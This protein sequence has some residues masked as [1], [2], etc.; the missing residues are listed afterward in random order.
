MVANPMVRRVA[1]VEAT[2]AQFNGKPLAYGKSDC[3]RMIAFALKKQ[4]HRVSLLKGGRYSSA[5]GACRALKTLGFETVLD[6]V[7]GHGLPRIAPALCL[8]GDVMALPAEAF[9]GALMLAVGNG[10]AFGYF[11]GQ[12]QVGQPLMFETAWRSI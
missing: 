6:A 12:F 10:R 11:D 5:L 9:G 3:I 7:D 1:A 4:G 2:I 8:P